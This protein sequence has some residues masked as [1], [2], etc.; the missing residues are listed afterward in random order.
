MNQTIQIQAAKKWVVIA[1]VLV[2]I[3]T[4]AFGYVRGM[5]P[6]ADA[7]G[8]L[9]FLL[10]IPIQWIYKLLFDLPIQLP[11]AIIESGDKKWRNIYAVLSIA[12]YLFVIGSIYK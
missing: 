9:A 3:S 6:I 5:L 11:G 1:L 4:I 2:A 12:A 7:L 10:G 8:R